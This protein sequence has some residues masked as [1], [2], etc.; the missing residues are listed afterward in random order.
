MV[1]KF[2][3]QIFFDSE[4][5]TVSTKLLPVKQPQQVERESCSAVGIVTN[6]D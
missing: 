1:F 2:T 6:D 5:G 4:D 3:G